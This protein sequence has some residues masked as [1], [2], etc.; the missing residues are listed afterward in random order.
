MAVR[1]TSTWVRPPATKL[2][3]PTGMRG[4]GTM[5]AQLTRTLP[6][7]ARIWSQTTPM[8]SGPAT[9]VDTMMLVCATKGLIAR[10]GERFHQAA[11]AISQAATKLEVINSSRRVLLPGSVVGLQLCGE[12]L[13][14]LDPAAAG[15]RRVA[16]FGEQ[17]P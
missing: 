10:R 9:T 15:G 16:V 4:T 2:G 7:R 1:T 5:R 14:S 6:A 3:K 8:G 12:F 11:D 17:G 13:W